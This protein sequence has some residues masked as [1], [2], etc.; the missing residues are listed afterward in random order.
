MHQSQLFQK[1]MFSFT[2]VVTRHLNR[3]TSAPRD[4]QLQLTTRWWDRQESL[5]SALEAFGW[6][7]SHS[8]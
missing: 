5:T 2:R 8:G 1:L 6:Q 3:V 4:N 7:A